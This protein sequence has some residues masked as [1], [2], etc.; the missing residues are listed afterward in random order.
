MSRRA[1]WEILMD[2]FDPKVPVR[3]EAWRAS[4]ERSPAAAI[5]RSLDVPRGIP[6]VLLTGTVG[7]GKTTELL[8]IAEAR[9]AKEF[10]VFLSLER[11]FHEVV[12][13]LPAL[14]NVSAWEVCF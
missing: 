11:H 3:K 9:T 5:V 7:T 2:R 1:V 13:D 8:R 14:Q 4:R 12:G 6:R 10:V